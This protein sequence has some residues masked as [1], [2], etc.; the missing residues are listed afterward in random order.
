MA[1]YGP[2]DCDSSGYT[3]MRSTWFSITNYIDVIDWYWYNCIDDDINLI[4]DICHDNDRDIFVS[5][6]ICKY[7]VYMF[8]LI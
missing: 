4:N 6:Y 8:V 3:S 5:W 2:A 7:Y 1:Q